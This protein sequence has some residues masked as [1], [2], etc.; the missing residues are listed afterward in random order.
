M[1][2]DINHA[3]ASPH[4]PPHP[5]RV[6]V[7]NDP[8]RLQMSGLITIPPTMSAVK[9]EP[10]DDPLPPSPS[11]AGSHRAD[12]TS[13]FLKQEEIARIESTPPVSPFQPHTRT[14]KE[15]N[16][17]S[18]ILG[19]RKPASTS[20]QSRRVTYSGARRGRHEEFVDEDS[21][22]GMGDI[23]VAGPSTTDKLPES[24]RTREEK[25]E[26]FRQMN[27][28]SRADYVRAYAP[29]KGRGRYAQAAPQYVFY[30]P[31][32][33]DYIE[34]RCLRYRQ[35]KEPVAAL[36]EINRDRNDGLDF[37]YDGVER[38]KAKRRQ[39]DATDCECCRDVRLFL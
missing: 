22:G 11:T 25:E 34:L 31:H 30:P 32:V 4:G 27:N 2:F 38:N 16:V 14:P 12:P 9:P 6:E 24:F 39:M 29:Y 5:P 36:F 23:S 13:F 33:V 20:R 8:P 17:L 26:F 10:Q 18:T 21:D 3:G 1:N 15:T 37:Q 28:K 7:L 35:D 19:K